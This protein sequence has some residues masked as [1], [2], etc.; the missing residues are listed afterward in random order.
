MMNDQFAA[1]LRHHLLEN[2]NERPA[3]GQLETVLRRTGIE[4]QY[5]PWVA[6]LR[7]RPELGGVGWQVRY[8]LAAVALLLALAAAA[9]WY[10]GTLPAPGTVFQGRW[11]STDIA[12]DSIQ[13]LVVAPGRSPAV[14]FE[15]A[16]SINCER[17]GERSTVYLADGAGEIDGG[18]LT[19]SFPTGGCGI[20]LPPFVWFYDYDAATRTLVDYQDIVWVR[21]P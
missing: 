7:M 13:T 18:R 9:A 17:R 10:A 14:H 21:A 1:D 4:P 11:T 3:E 16:F 20:D 2:A 15:D 6:R 19:V 5:R 12:D 8:G